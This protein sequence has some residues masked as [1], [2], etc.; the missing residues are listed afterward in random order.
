MTQHTGP[1][2]T[3][4]S[5][6]WGR[7][8][9]WINASMM[10]EAWKT[11]KTGSSPAPISQLG[12]NMP[13]RTWE[14]KSEVAVRVLCE[15]SH[16]CNS[17]VWLRHR[18]RKARSLTLTSVGLQEGVWVAGF[19]TPAP[20]PGVKKKQRRVTHQHGTVQSRRSLGQRSFRYLTGGP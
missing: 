19:R 18:L 2:L 15:E 11:L 20:F 3:V 13:S 6:A 14:G 17:G 1:G 5:V 9:G 12:P 8:G 4:V 16:K 7:Y 10:G